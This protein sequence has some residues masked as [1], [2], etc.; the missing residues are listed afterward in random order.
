MIVET[1]QTCGAR[2]T[3][4][5]ACPP[6]IAEVPSLPRVD[7][8]DAL[9]APIFYGR[10]Q[11]QAQL[12]QWVV[13]ER[14]RVVSVL[15]MGGIGKSVLSASL[16]YR[17][18]EH[19]QVVIFRSLRDAP[20]CEALLDGCLQVL[21]PQHL[22]VS[23]AE[24]AQGTVSTER[25]I[26]LLLEQM[27]KTRTLL[28]LDNLESLLQEG[29]PGG[30]FRHDFEGYGQL[31]CRMAEAMHQSCLLITSRE[32]PAVLRPLE[33]RYS[34][35]HSLRLSGLG[36]VACKQLCMEKEL[37]GI[38]ADQERL[39][40]LY[41]GNPLALKIVAEIIIDLFSGEIGSFLGSGA[42][43]FGSISDLLG[44]QFARLSALEQSVLYWLAIAREPMTLDELL[45]VLV[46]PL[47]RF[48]VLEAVDGLHRR[49]LIERGKRLGSFTLQSV[50]L[51][52]VTGIL[53]TEGSREIKLGRLDR[54]IEHGLSQ[55]CAKEYVRQ[56]R[57]SDC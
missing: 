30:H 35:V 52:Y 25:R 55:A 19:F 23:S 39:I 32:K 5:S 11:E 16:M 14:C 26:L 57:R 7:W 17:L 20:P 15:G 40:A 44:E 48:Q 43:V 24:Q 2:H 22:G 49:S 6:V 33:G 31:L 13:Q 47:P 42:L 34:L 28:V 53:I 18:A 8:G 3:G 38:E 9:I 56:E 51:E 21:S 29:D 54:L 46:I 36:L 37:V 45:V 27:R 10:E 1:V 50:V 4:Y 12:T 41:G